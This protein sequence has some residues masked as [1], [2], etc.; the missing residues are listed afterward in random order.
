MTHKDFEAVYEYSSEL[1][2]KVQ[3]LYHH[4]LNQRRELRRLNRAMR[5][6]REGIEIG[7]QYVDQGV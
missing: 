6:L 2:N 5:T 1:Y 7:R 4:T 3:D